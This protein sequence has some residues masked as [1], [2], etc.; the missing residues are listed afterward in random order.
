MTAYH[1][2]VD[3]EW[4]GGRDGIGSVQSKGFRTTVSIDR[5][6]NGR[7]EG[8]NP[9]ELLISATQACYMM[10]LGIALKSR[11]LDFETIQVH[12]EGVVSDENGLHFESITHYPM[13]TVAPDTTEERI[14]E[15]MEA[16]Y[17]AEERCMIGNALRGNVK[18]SVQPTVK[19]SERAAG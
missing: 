16:A 5:S 15:I 2:S 14:A 9:D 11:G 7:G 3:G 19:K 10:T 17:R 13:I 12:S 18:L 6:M 1:F 8:T 4:K